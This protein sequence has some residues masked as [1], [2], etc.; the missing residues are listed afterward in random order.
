[1]NTPLAQRKYR[2]TRRLATDAAKLFALWAAVF[3]AAAVATAI[4]RSA[5]GT[6]VEFAS[7]VIW[8]VPLMMFFLSWGHL[9]KFYPQAVAGGLTRKAFLGAYAAYGTAAVLAVAALTQIGRRLLEFFSSDA[10][11]VGFYGL[12]LVESIVRPALFFAFGTAV[13]AAMFRI[14]SRRIGVA[15]GVAA[16]LLVFYRS[17][18]LWANLVPVIWGDDNGIATV[19]MSHIALIDLALAVVFALAAGGLLARAPMRP[20]PA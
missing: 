20:K 10:F 3:T 15:V 19:T 8:A 11:N 4:V 1:M 14:P 5:T 12:G 7:Y 6:H 18:W 9:T 2:I 13:A 16:S 17:T